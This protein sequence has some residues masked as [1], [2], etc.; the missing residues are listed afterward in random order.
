MDD[1][2]AVFLFTHCVTDGHF[3]QRPAQFSGK[4]C[5]Y[6]RFYAAFSLPTVSDSW[7]LSSTTCSHQWQG[8]ATERWCTDTHDYLAKRMCFCWAKVWHAQ[9]LRAQA[10][11]EFSSPFRK[12]RP[13]FFFESSVRFLLFLAVSARARSCLQSA[14]LCTAKPYEL[15]ADLR[16]YRYRYTGTL[17]LHCSLQTD[18][19]S[20]HA[21]AVHAVHCACT[22]DTPAL[23]MFQAENAG[24]KQ[25]DLVTCGTP[26]QVCRTDDLGV[27]VSYR[28]LPARVLEFFIW[29]RPG[30]SSSL[31]F[32]W[33]VVL[34]QVLCCC[35]EEFLKFSTMD[36]DS[37]SEDFQLVLSDSPP[38]SPAWSPLRLPSESSAASD[39]DVAGPLSEGDVSPGEE[40]VSI[41]SQSED[42]ATLATGTRKRKPVAIL[43][44]TDSSSSEQET[45]APQASAASRKKRRCVRYQTA[46]EE[47]PLLKGWLLKS[48]KDGSKA[49]CK[50]CCKELD[51]GNG[52]ALDLE[53]HGK[54]AVLLLISLLCT[55]Q[56][57]KLPWWVHTLWL[58]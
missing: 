35:R 39:S 57:T 16:S 25:F 3:P 12:N 36:S 24:R 56:A 1:I 33:W 8:K 51:F 28:T 31:I 18:A 58:T 2:Y 49:F 30:W 27:R 32:F 41:E 11:S 47:K 19:G 9:P 13:I 22:R 23:K 15:H 17:V 48:S 34:A 14:D 52:G 10:H 21:H 20:S 53:R 37:Q 55:L 54:S 5:T 6:W 43:D 4:A 7:W 38:S 40:P 44:S 46:W 29:E 45:P 26:K 42:E 50:I